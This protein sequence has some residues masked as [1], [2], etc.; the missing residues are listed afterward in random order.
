M[1]KV[2]IVADSTCDL[3]AELIAKYDITINPLC[4][5]MEEKSY[6]DGIDVKP[7]EI[8]EWANKNKTTPYNMVELTWSFNHTEQTPGQFNKCSS[9]SHHWTQFYGYENLYNH[10]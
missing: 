5:I 1:K 6:F 3:S 4:I 9:T 8:F 2:R 7:E 10:L